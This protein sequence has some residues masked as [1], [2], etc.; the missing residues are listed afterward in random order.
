MF[1][2]SG[3]Q[4]QAKSL[5][6]KIRGPLRGQQTAV[7]AVTKQ[8]YIYN[9]GNNVKTVGAKLSLLGE[10]GL[11]MHALAG[12]N[13]PRL[14]MRYILRGGGEATPVLLLQLKVRFTGE[15]VGCGARRG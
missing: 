11:C 2:L 13:T 6:Q 15:I 1:L 5:E 14:F 8:L 12:L 3:K 7:S 4:E 9:S 10:W